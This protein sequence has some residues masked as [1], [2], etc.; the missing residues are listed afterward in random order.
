MGF[1]GSFQSS[2]GKLAAQLGEAIG[3]GLGELTGSYFANNALNSVIN[4]PKLKNADSAERISA[5]QSKLAP[6]G[7]RGEKMLLRQLELEE[8]R[9]AKDADRLAARYYENPNSLTP[10]QRASL[11]SDVIAKEKTLNKPSKT[12]ATNEPVPPEQAQKIEQILEENP[13]DNAEQLGVKFAKA[14]IHPVYSSPYLESRRRIGEKKTEKLNN[15][16]EKTIESLS[17]APGKAITQASLGAII[18]GTLSGEQNPGSWADIARI[19]GI[20][21]FETPGAAAAATAGKEFM[22][23][24]LNDIRGRP[25]QFLEQQITKSLT[26]TGLPQN[27]NAAKARVLKFTV[28]ATNEYDKIVNDLVDKDNYPPG[29]LKIEAQKRYAE[30]EDKEQVKLE[31]DIKDITKGNYRS[32]DENRY[33]ENAREKAKQFPDH[34][35]I[36]NSDGTI[37]LWTKAKPLPPGAKAL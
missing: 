1:L 16:D 25:N 11:P 18:N 29:K 15:R 12:A 7:Q 9:A 30:W 6:F 37:G 26:E 31:K 36:E 19:T 35:L 24:S 32:L 21:A 5:L 28:D 22:I 4:D 2:R 14:G 3:G 13:N 20:K 10:E 27:A 23:H 17:T 34:I 33:I 8:K